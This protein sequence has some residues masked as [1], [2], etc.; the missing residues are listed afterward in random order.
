MQVSMTILRLLI[1]INE[2]VRIHVLIKENAGLQEI[3][4]EI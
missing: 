3:F 2:S 1:T 4:A